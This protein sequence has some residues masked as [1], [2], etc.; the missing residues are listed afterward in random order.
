LVED[1]KHMRETAR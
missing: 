1:N